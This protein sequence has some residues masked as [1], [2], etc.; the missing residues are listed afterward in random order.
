[1]NS[2]KKKK[3]NAY[4]LFKTNSYQKVDDWKLLLFEYEAHPTPTK[5]GQ[6]PGGNIPGMQSILTKF[7]QF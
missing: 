6:K 1:M 2:I 7:E 4:V 5:S 3:K